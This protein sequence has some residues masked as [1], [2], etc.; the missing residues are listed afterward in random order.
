[1]PAYLGVDLSGPRRDSAYAALGE[2]LECRVGHFRGDE[3]LLELVLALKPSIVAIDAPLT[4]PAEGYMR[5]C[6]EA[7]A[8]LGLKPLPP[9]LRGMK[10]I[11]LRGTR[12]REA[13]EKS[14]YVVIEVYPGG[15][16][17]IL[18]IARK[19]KGLEALRR[20]IERL[21]VRLPGRGLDGDELDAAT[22][23]YTAYAYAHGRFFEV[24]GP[25][26]RIVFPLPPRGA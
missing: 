1:M 25:G 19:K 3:E 26:C 16:Q 10:T 5:P 11:T 7:L 9:M 12:L 23:A 21:G 4:L 22:A 13:L 24:S 2:D 15:A 20:G 8:R 14:G 18:R 6:D 17:D